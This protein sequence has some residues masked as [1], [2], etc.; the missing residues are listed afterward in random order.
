LQKYGKQLFQVLILLLVCISV[1]ISVFFLLSISNRVTDETDFFRSRNR[2]Y[3]TDTINGKR[4]VSDSG[5]LIISD[6][7]IPPGVLLLMVNNK[8]IVDS[9][10]LDAELS[11]FSG[12]DDVLIW[13]IDNKQQVGNEV[14]VKA[15]MLNDSTLS[16]FEN[17]LIVMDVEEGGVASRA[18]IKRGDIVVAINDISISP[19][20]TSANI[21]DNLSPGNIAKYDI[22]RGDQNIEINVKLAKFG[23]SIISF[24]IF[25][26]AMLCYFIGGFI[27][28]K[29]PAVK[30]ARLAS[31][32]I[33]GV[34]NLIIIQQDFSFDETVGGGLMGLYLVLALFIVPALLLHS[35]YYF[36]EQNK[37][38]TTRRWTVLIPY[39]IGII[40][41][42][43][44]MGLIAVSEDDP[45]DTAVNVVFGFVAAII[46][47]GLIVHLS[48]KPETKPSG[49]ARTLKASMVIVPL[50]FI[51]T[52]FFSIDYGQLNRL[53]VLVLVLI[54]F[55][56]LYTMVKSRLLEFDFKVR[57]NV[58]YA[59]SY[60]II[61]LGAVIT[62]IV[63]IYLISQIELQIPNL[64]FRGYE[65]EVIDSELSDT[66]TA[67]WTRFIL[68]FISLI[69][70]YGIYRLYQIIYSNMQRVFYREAGDKTSV[71]KQLEESIPESGKLFENLPSS[72]SKVMQ[73]YS[74][75]IIEIRKGK[76]VNLYSYRSHLDIRSLDLSDYS[77][78]IL[79]IAEEFDKAFL[80]DYLPESASV[81]KK[82]FPFT[83]PI[84]IGTKLEALVLSGRKLSDSKY[85]EKDIEL[86]EYIA[87]GISQLME[88]DQLYNEVAKRERVHQEI[89]LARKIQKLSL[90]TKMPEAKGLDIAAFSNPAYEVGGDFYEMYAENDRLTVVIGDVS[91]KGASAAM[92]MSKAQG[93]TA[94]LN[95][96]EASPGE[97]LKKFNK[98]LEPYMVRGDY[99]TALCARFDTKRSIFEYSRAGHVPMLHF[100]SGTREIS[101][102]Q[103]KG[104][105]IGF[106]GQKLFDRNLE[107]VEI[108]YEED[109]IFVLYTDGLDEARNEIGEEYGT[110]RLQ[111]IIAENS[112]LNS[113]EMIDL[114]KE[115][116]REFTGERSQFDD[117]SVCIIKANGDR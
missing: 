104:L 35:T 37:N 112:H 22:I 102:Y 39:V 63:S 117:L 23:I 67:F 38:I 3:T 45:L 101:A 31:L 83:A 61:L 105:G 75:A 108:K 82:E 34:G 49:S 114:I 58:Q 21:L 107:S 43:V 95:E 81:L 111:K 99:L 15:D 1:S 97:F 8:P 30:A 46:L 33:I 78:E 77:K 115:R 52:Q 84:R 26:C 28:L 86:L 72:I 44:I 96:F 93:M 53:F 18:G 68:T 27:G 110:D 20:I 116:I 9:Y 5:G 42:A 51:L 94:A 24:S 106:Q 55:V 109:D 25:L 50:V 70:I 54:P 32:A 4:V 13:V 87:S 19:S 60:I 7:T 10:E 40:S 73:T 69:T 66:K 113:K 64:H 14:V 56:Y 88:R 76:L 91:G 29:R 71:Y 48:F 47:F 89:E 17:A 6:Y 59:V 11:R 12:Q 80:T 98:L 65:L 2:I 74:A 62:G 100:H 36:P 103:T 85:R 16:S 90:P 79:E 41:L 57:R 92:Y